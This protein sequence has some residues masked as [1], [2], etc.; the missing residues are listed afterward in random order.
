MM[1]YLLFFFILPI[2]LFAQEDDLEA[3]QEEKY[4]L[5]KEEILFEEPEESNI[6]FREKTF[7][8]PNAK[9]S[10]FFMNLETSLL[11]YKSDVSY[12]GI[13]ASVKATDSLPLIGPSLGF[14]YRF[15]W[16][17]VS[18]SGQVNLFRYTNRDHFSGKASE[19]IPVMISEQ[20]N[21]NTITGLE[22]AQR[23]YMTFQLSERNLIEPFIQVGLGYAI[24]ESKFEH[25]YYDYENSEYYLATVDEQLLTQNLAIGFNIMNRNGLYFIFKVQKNVLTIGERDTQ[26]AEF[27]FQGGL[28]SPS[29]TADTTVDV[30]QNRDEFSVTLG[31]GYVF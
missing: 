4:A 19:E 23:F 15:R 13:K 12:T 30:N 20:E 5:E 28:G 11:M 10:H 3:T 14:G 17:N 31:A 18:T 8:S 21:D 24:S 25:Y 29:T 2:T 16:G 9:K 6:F 26:I 27:A 1:K 7:I 22:Y